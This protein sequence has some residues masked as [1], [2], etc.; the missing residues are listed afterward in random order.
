VLTLDTEVPSFAVPAKMAKYQ[1]VIEFRSSDHR[2]LNSRF[3][4]DD[5]LWHGFMTA[6]Y[7]RR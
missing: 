4:G 7:R 6:N 2:V 1:D 3:L 5:G